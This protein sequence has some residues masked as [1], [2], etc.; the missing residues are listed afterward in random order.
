MSAQVEPKRDRIPP[1]AYDVAAVA[2]VLVV[3][4]F[5]AFLGPRFNVFPGFVGFPHMEFPRS[6]PG[7]PRPGDDAGVTWLYLWIQLPLLISAS[8]LLARRGWPMVAYGVTFATLVLVVFGSAPP[9]GPAIALTIAVFGL[10]N[11]SSQ[12]VAFVSGGAAAVVILVVSFAATGWQSLEPRLLQVAAAVAIA[13]ALGDSTRSRREYV[14][15][16]AKRAEHA[17]QTREAEAQRRV[18]DERLRIARD[19][20]DTVAHEISVISLNAGVASGA[21]EANPE[22]ARQALATIRRASRGA[23]AEIGELLHY[24][25]ADGTS[26]VETNPPRPILEN[27]PDLVRDLSEGGLTVTINVEGELSAVSG[28][29]GVV[30]YRII[31]EGL[32]NAHKYGAEG[33]AHV[34]IVVGEEVRL[35]VENP[36]PAV[37]ESKDVGVPQPPGSGLGLVGV[38]ERVATL[39][40][41]VT[42]GRVGDLWILE[43]SLPL[44][45]G[46][47]V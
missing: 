46:E 21:L 42:A 28:G 43:A 33:R 5:F 12:R 38:R 11:R 18:A 45:K 37:F 19:L 30:V 17:E 47:S 40:G 1:W 16:M 13:A 41:S 25:R 36:V 15:A 39:G 2:A 20:H 27:L 32:T 3:G 24:L 26:G 10:A 22:R 29:T 34:H 14:D 4:G 6:S 31:Q 9:L 35:R 8:A 7:G 44:K 23:L